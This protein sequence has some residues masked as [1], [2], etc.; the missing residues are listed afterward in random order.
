MSKNKITLLS[1]LVVN[2]RKKGKKKK[3]REEKKKENLYSQPHDLVM[4]YYLLLLK[5]NKG[6]IL[7]DISTGHFEKAWRGRMEQGGITFYHP[8]NCNTFLCVLCFLFTR[9]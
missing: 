4:S 9:L 2:Y 1:N 5:K 7:N 3:R 8:L 6:I